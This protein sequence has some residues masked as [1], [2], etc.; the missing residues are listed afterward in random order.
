VACEQKRRHLPQTFVPDISHLINIAVP[1]T[2]VFPLVAAGPGF[3]QWWAEDVVVAQDGSAE[4]G[5]YDRQTVFRLRPQTHLTERRATWVCD[6]GG[7]WAGTRLTFLLTSTDSG[8]LLRL[9]HADWREE[10]EL[11]TRC[12]TTWGAL[13]YHLKAVAEGRSHQ[14]LFS[15]G[16]ENV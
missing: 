13:V 10:S 7:E 4:L 14:P 1:P 16:G 11:F 8:T 3:R 2:T 6:K 15:A 5:F 9:E 12:N